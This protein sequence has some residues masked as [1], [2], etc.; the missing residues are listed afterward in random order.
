[1]N[2][3]TSF[4]LLNLK[5]SPRYQHG[6]FTL[7]HQHIKYSDSLS[8]FQEYK[9]FFNIKSIENQKSFNIGRELGKKRLLL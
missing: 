2:L 7:A 5:K 6:I 1:M 8:T 9:D 4:K 3:F